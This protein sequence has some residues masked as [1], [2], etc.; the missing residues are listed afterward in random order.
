M[1]TTRLCLS[2]QDVGE[3][4]GLIAMCD[5]NH[6]HGEIILLPAIESGADALHALKADIV[7]D[8]RTEE[9]WVPIRQSGH[10]KNCSHS[11]HQQNR[12]EDQKGAST[13]SGLKR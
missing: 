3:V 2:T 1:L 10:P 12:E 11:T 7:E 13:G 4:S 8:L 5:M 9:G 6:Q